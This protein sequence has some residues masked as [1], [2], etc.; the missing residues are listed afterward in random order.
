MET[1]MTI[2]YQQILA[3]VRD[4]VQSRCL[5]ATNQLHPAFYEFHLLVV[6][7]YALQLAEMLKADR[8][9]VQIAALLHD[10]SAVLDFSTLPTHAKDSAS[11]AREILEAS[12][13]SDLKKQ[14]IIHCIEAHVK[15]LPFGA[16][17]AEAICIS[18]ADA[19]AFIAM[20][21]YWIYFAYT[22]NK[23]DYGVGLQWYKERV[24]KN[25]LNLIRPA[26]D[27][28]YESYLHNNLLFEMN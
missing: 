13:L 20:P 7:K 27:M 28:I 9:V 21:S 11:I 22:I 4:Y 5:A 14:N 3:Q 12:N 23:M 1:K 10:I 17:T 8:E 25:W 16:D 24:D 18:N 15:P 6:E 26:C 2:N 19:M